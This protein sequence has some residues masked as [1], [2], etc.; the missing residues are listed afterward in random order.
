M[1]NRNL[2]FAVSRLRSFTLPG[3]QIFAR[4]SLFNT[5]ML[6]FVKSKYVTFIA[7]KTGIINLFKFKN[8][9]S[10]SQTDKESYFVPLIVRLYNF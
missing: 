4:R 3:F 7:Q 8:Q 5:A 2:Q 6:F 9:T 10:T 1:G